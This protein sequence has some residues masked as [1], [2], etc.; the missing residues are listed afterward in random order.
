MGIRRADLRCASIIKRSESSCHAS[1]QI[2]GADRLPSPN[3]K[4]AIQHYDYIRE[5]LSNKFAAD[6][7]LNWNGNPTF[8]SGIIPGDGIVLGREFT[9][10][11]LVHVKGCKHDKSGREGFDPKIIEDL[12]KVEGHERAVEN[13][14]IVM[15]QISLRRA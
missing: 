2:T 11:V 9:K 4:H 5:Y 7:I 13:G 8:D 1:F 12:E 10:P 6:G 3:P 14:E 15:D